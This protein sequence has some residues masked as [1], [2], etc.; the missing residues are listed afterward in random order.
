MSGK[1]NRD[2]IESVDCFRYVSQFYYINLANP[3]TWEIFSTSSLI[4][5]FKDLK[6]L[7]YR[8]FI[9]LVTPRY[10]IWFVTIM[11][12]VFPPIS[13]SACLPFEWRNGTD[14]FEAILYSN[15]F[16]KLCIRF[17]SYLVEF[18]GSLKYSIISSANSDILTS[19]FPI[20]IPLT[21]FVV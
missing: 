12:G 7:S 6:I 8:S 21:S 9:F 3:C 16:L 1:F 18:W 17:R 2:C 15:T 5:F 10:F 11:K 19:P 13:F 4:S 20:Y 14:L